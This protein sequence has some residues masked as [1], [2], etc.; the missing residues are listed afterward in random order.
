V[1][2]LDKLPVALIVAEVEELNTRP[3]TCSLRTLTHS[4]ATRVPVRRA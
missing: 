1:D 4:A 3:V 2:Q